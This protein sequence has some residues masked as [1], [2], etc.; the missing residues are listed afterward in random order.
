MRWS[1]QERAVR[2]GEENYMSKGKRGCDEHGKLLV[3]RSACLE[4]MM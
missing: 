2:A 1:R 3:V 4:H